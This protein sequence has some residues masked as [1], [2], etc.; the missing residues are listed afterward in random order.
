MNELFYIEK[1][2]FLHH[3]V[4]HLT[5]IAEIWHHVAHISS[6]YSC[7]WQQLDLTLLGSSYIIVTRMPTH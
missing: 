5:R 2:L 7:V 4:C 6:I 3:V 1:M